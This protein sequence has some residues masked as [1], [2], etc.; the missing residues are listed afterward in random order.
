[1]GQMIV[2]LLFTDREQLGKINGIQGI[3]LKYGDYLLAHGWHCF[4]LVVAS[5]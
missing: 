1:M 3:L 2:H 4:S 5:L